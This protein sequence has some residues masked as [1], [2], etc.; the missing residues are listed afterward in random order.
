MPAYSGNSCEIITLFPMGVEC[1]VIDAYTPFTNDGGISLFITGGTP[2]YSINWS[3]GSHSQNLTNL[4]VGNYTATVVDYYGDFTGTTTCTVGNVTFYLEEFE[5]CTSPGSYIYY[6][7]NMGSQFSAN[8]IYSLNLQSGCWISNGVLL[9]TAQTYYNYSAITSTGPFETCVQ[10]IPTVPQLLN[11]SG[12]CLT[13]NYLNTQSQ[14]QFYSGGTINGYPSW[15]ASTPNQTIYYNTGTT[16]WVISGWSLNG[17]PYLQTPYSP[18]IG[19]WTVAGANRTVSLSVGECEDSISAIITSNLPSCVAAQNGTIQVTNVIGGNSPYEYS[20]NNNPASY[21]VSNTFTNLP[22]GLYTVYVQDIIGNVSANVVNLQSSTNVSQY[23]INLNLVP[24]TVLPTTNTST[25]IVKI[26]NWEISVSP[27][28]PVGKTLTFDI[29][30]VANVVRGNGIQSTATNVSTTGTTGGGSYISG[31]TLSTT[32]SSTTTACSSTLT[33]T[34][35]VTSAITRTYKAKII[36]VGTVKGTVVS[37]INTPAVTTGC[38]KT[39]TINNN[40]SITNVTLSN[41]TICETL[42]P[43]VTLLTFNTTKTG[44]IS[45]GPSGIIG[46]QN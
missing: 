37:T 6:L 32:L 11:V 36:G 44:L 18:P 33:Y 4:Q 34:S 19:L 8:T 28:L 21:Q 17:T 1:S 29:T 26:F 46:I 45:M 3:N 38:A 20:L 25:Q 35:Y 24:A 13:T 2:P 40:I 27:S 31:T 7:A 14:Y 42:N 43:N 10:C 30:H 41:Q 16:M 12:M 22:S 9:Y 5:S 15:S 23:T 39:A